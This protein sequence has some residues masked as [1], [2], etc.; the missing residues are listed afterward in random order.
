[1]RYVYDQAPGSNNSR[2]KSVARFGTDAVIDAS[3][4]L[5]G[6][7]ALPAVVFNYR[8]FNTAGNG[9]S[10]A[11]ASWEK[12]FAS[13]CTDVSVPGRNDLHF[14]DVNNDGA[15]ELAHFKGTYCGS[16]STYKFLLNRFD[17]LNPVG[18]VAQTTADGLAVLAGDKLPGSFLG[19]GTNKSI[20]VSKF[21]Q[22]DS[23]GGSSSPASTYCSTTNRSIT[24]GADLTP[25]VAACSSTSGPFAEDCTNFFQSGY[26]SSYA[27][28]QP[29]GCRGY[30][31]SHVVSLPSGE[32]KISRTLED[33]GFVGNGDYAGDGIVT[34]VV[35]SWNGY[36]YQY[37][38]ATAPVM[39]GTAIAGPL[40]G[41]DTSFLAD[42]N[43]DGLTD[44]IVKNADR[45]VTYNTFRMD[46][47]VYL[48]TG[49]SFQALPATS[50]EPS[51]LFDLASTS[52]RDPYSGYTSYFSFASTSPAMPLDLDGDGKAE[53]LFQNGVTNTTEMTAA[54]QAVRFGFAGTVN[55]IIAVS[56][57]TPTIKTRHGSGDING[58]SLPDFPVKITGGNY[59]KFLLS[60]GAEGLP[61]SLL[62]VKNELGGVHSFKFRP[63]T[64]YV[65]QYLPFPV[66]TIA[67]IA[68]DDGRGGVALQKISYAG[69]KYDPALRRFMGFRTVTETQP[70]FASETACPSSE[71][72]YR[73]D[74]ASAGAPE[75]VVT[76]DGAG[77]VKRT[78]NETYDVRATLKPFYARNTATETILTDGQAMT[79]MTERAFDAYGNVTDVKEHGRVD[80]P[81]DELRVL[82]HFSH[83]LAKFITGKPYSVRT[84]ASLDDNAPRIQ[85]SDFRYDGAASI[86]APL[87]G[88][89]TFQYD[90][91]NTG[92]NKY[93]SSTYTYD[94]FGNRKSLANALNETT[95]WTYDGAF[96]LHVTEETNALGQKT[97]YAPN[98]ACGAPA[99]RTGP[100][101]VRFEFTYDAFC[102]KTLERNTANG[103]FLET[104]Y[105]FTGSPQT[106]F[107]GTTRPH[108]GGVAYH[109]SWLDGLGRVYFERVTGSPS[110]AGA[111][112]T[113]DSETAYD[114]R[115]NVIRKSLPYFPGE[116]P[117]YVVTSYDWASR[118]L[119]VTLPGGAKRTF[120]YWN[121]LTVAG[122]SNPSLSSVAAT[123]ELGRRTYTYY[124]TRGDVILV[125]RQIG[126]SFQ[127]E[128]RSYDALGRMIGVTDA[129]G[130]QWVNAYDML[131]NRVLAKDPD[132]GTWTYV[133]DAANRLVSQTDARNVRTAMTYDGLGRLLTRRIAAPVVADPLLTSNTYDEARPGYA[134]NIG[135]LTSSVNSARAQMFDYA[136][137]G[138]VL[139]RVESDAAGSHE[140]LY[141]LSPDGSVR[142]KTWSAPAPLSVGTNAAPWTYDALGRLKSVPGMI[143]AQTYETDG[144]TKSIAYANNVVTTFLYDPNR[145]WLTRV[146][147]KNSAGTALIDNVYT[148]D[149][150]GRITRIDGLTMPESWIYAYDDL[151][152]LVSAGNR[153]DST[154][155]E[156]FTYDIADNMLSR[157]RN[158][159]GAGAPGTGPFAYVYPAG[160]LARPHAPVSVAGRVFTYDNNGNML[161]DG[162]KSLAFDHANRLASVLKGGQTTTF[163]YGPDGARAKKVSPLGTTRY[164]GAEAEEKGGVYTRYP[165]MDVM[166]QGST[167]SF[168][169]RDHLNTVKMVTNNLGA[170]TERTG[171]AAF[172]EPKPSTS[173]PKG[174]IGERPDVETG[175]LYLNARYYDPAL[176]RF[177]SP[178][179]WDPTLSGVGTNRYAYAGQ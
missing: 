41:T 93:V 26:Y 14:L 176:G 79:L 48:A 46:V 131:G 168:L 84:S 173:L 53:I 118:P 65:N 140:T 119:S 101:N 110:P 39:S 146:T 132:L 20:L 108:A 11:Y 16:T 175:M 154:L 58:D 43:G 45:S 141:G 127:Q 114:S 144:Q 160:T 4:A 1:M 133:Y 123:D 34:P 91:Q 32:S 86:V 111:S 51:F 153:G 162:L 124:S 19:V 55:S 52:F 27:G 151:D 63:S 105:N 89:L 143:L 145:R 115:G 128:F 10:T 9:Y 170:V 117:K 125:L 109:N 47:K 152:R 7:T 142:F 59:V 81:G 31:Q 104:R 83:N 116:T 113:H 62:S 156:T 64:R 136:A 94:G 75:K 78:V 137:S 76:K 38:A 102:R 164:F 130:A 129:A 56:G 44:I 179:D 67:E 12:T 22:T 161:A 88:K 90:F 40:R 70:C 25:T 165:H 30:F 18:A 126:A 23:S 68:A 8:D 60:N 149:A 158:P 74:P 172:G 103:H 24:F 33:T 72:T 100:D 73:Q 6:G 121:L 178:D 155:G 135:R 92:Q 139:H 80:M 99:A 21:E 5:T 69:G 2:L 77:A 163:G 147:T 29:P 97:L 85:Q 174:F 49:V 112:I 17:F 50:V 148:R 61:N 66:S 15:D 169:H 35:A 36:H 13:P 177:I 120:A 96:G 37:E 42:V 166:V 107:A 167:I 171:Y 122:T 150:A 54:Y 87:Y 134:F 106:Q 3:G 157:G 159:A 82:T 28:G 138:A 57:F 71:T 98:F 95:S